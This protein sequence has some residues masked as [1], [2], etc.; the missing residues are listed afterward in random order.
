MYHIDKKKAGP[1]SLNKVLTRNY[2]LLVSEKSYRNLHS[3]L[4]DMINALRSKIFKLSKLY[5]L[6]LYANKQ[7][8]KSK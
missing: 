3:H 6:S 2:Y 5:S 8:G 4:T 1:L 7:L